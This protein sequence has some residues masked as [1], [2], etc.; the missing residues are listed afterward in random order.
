LFRDI[1]NDELFVT[2][3]E[4]VDVILA[5]KEELLLFTVDDSVSTLDAM[6]D[7]KFV[8]VV[9]TLVID[10]ASE[11]LFPDILLAN[12]SI[13]IAAEE[14]LVETVE[15]SV[16]IEELNDEEAVLNE[17][18]KVLTSVATEELKLVIVP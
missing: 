18:F 1:A 13:L 16:V 15:F 2:I 4:F 9:L 14:L 7:E 10:A 12:P 8:F 17:E 6:D 3:V 11:E 5:A